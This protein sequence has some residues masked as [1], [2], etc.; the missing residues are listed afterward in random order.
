WVWTA[1]VVNSIRVE[2]SSRPIVSGMHSLQPGGGALWRMQDQGELTDV[3]TT[4]PYPIFTPHCDNDPVNTIRGCLHATAESRYYADI[5]N[6]PVLAEELGTLGPMIS[7]EGVAANYVRTALFSLWSHDC[8][9]LL[10]WCGYDQ[11]RL[12]HA[13]YDWHSHERELGLIRSDRSPKPVF[14][15]LGA[16]GTFLQQLPISKLPPR[17]TEAVCILTHHQDQWAAA[18]SSF[19]MAKQA[20]FD[21]VFQY[22]D[23]PLKDAGLYLMPSVSGSRSFSRRFWLELEKR[24]RDGATLY[25]SHDDC[26]LSPFNATFGAA[27]Q[28][29]Q[30]RTGPVEIHMDKSTGLP[31]YSVPSSIKL[32]LKVE[33]ATVLGIEPDGNPAFICAPLDKGCVFFLSA[34]IEKVLSQTPGGYQEP[35]T[36][37]LWQ[38]YRYIARPFMHDRILD[39]DH[40]D[41]GI[42]E[43]VL[44]SVRR[45]AVLI[46]YSPEPAD[47]GVQVKPGWSLIES[48]Y[49]DPP[50]VSD[51]EFICSIAANDALVV[52]LSPTAE[53]EM[54]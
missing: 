10:W 9:G 43:H 30:R 21:V 36:C 25:L 31:G 41:V 16:F 40:G 37:E 13:P 2:D 17:V 53:L 24:V 20:G 49:G 44:D 26:M 46:N 33:R 39:K 12:Q 32:E 34:P 54:H 19:I 38:I 35:K 29:R 48:W 6:K 11:D 23:E 4:H 47:L 7:S 28:T 52:L 22:A 27:V 42:T 50:V 51:T 3:L 15:V 45:V 1:A 8:H 5:G 14:S 18:F